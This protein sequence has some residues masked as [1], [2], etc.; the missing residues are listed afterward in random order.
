MSRDNVQKE[1]L[2]LTLTK[3]RCGLGI[4]MGVGKTRIAIQHLIKNF[5]PFLSVLV[6]IPKLSVKDAWTSEIDKMDNGQQNGTLHL[7]DHITYSTYLSINK[8][9]P[10]DYDIVYLDECHS[11]LEGHENFLN[12]YTGKILGLTGTP[13]R[14]GSDKYKM[15][16]K[17][18]PIIYNFSVD[19]AADSNI[20]NDY[21]IIV[22][23]LQLSKLKTHKK[24]GKEGGYWYTSEKGDYDYYTSRLGDAQ[25]QKQKQFTSIM[26]MKSMMDYGTKEAYAKGLL[27]NI[28]QKCL[29]FANTQKQADRMCPNSYHSG[30]K[31]SE[32]N[33]DLFSD[34]R[35]NQ[36]SCV[37][38]LSEGVNIPGVKQGIIMHA[39]G[40][41]RKTAQRIG[42]LL[43]L[44][45]HE[46]ATCHILCYSNSVDM[47]WVDSALSTFDQ[48][49]I[50]YYNPLER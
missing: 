45:P 47:K 5:N 26:R 24:K 46:K 49:K 31:K 50:K 23:Q 6:V 41:E 48:D 8:Q 20:L 39:Y 36:L 12:A 14:K 9:N 35:I 34:G 16:N 43:R 3:K 29:V 10:N 18:C 33:L 7:H 28:N 19:E 25:T 1:A 21:Q 27:K 2:D 13:P 22:H 37:L 42:R 17:Y 40:N 15:V 38:Q 32:E 30:N 44:S 4:S 11:L